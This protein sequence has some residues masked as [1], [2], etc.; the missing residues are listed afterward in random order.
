MNKRPIGS[1][2]KR[3]NA[4]VCKTVTHRVN[5]VGSNPTATMQYKEWIRAGEEIVSK[6]TTPKGAEGSTPSHSVGYL[7]IR[8]SQDS[9]NFRPSQSTLEQ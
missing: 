9:R 1:V 7:G 8:G 6:T 4:T 3:L 5:I 2:A